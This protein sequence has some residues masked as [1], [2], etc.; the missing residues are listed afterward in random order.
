M[1][2]A[3]R[4]LRT[5]ESALPVMLHPKYT[6][7]LGFGLGVPKYSAGQWNVDRMYRAKNGLRMCVSGLL[8]SLKSHRAAIWEPPPPKPA[9]ER[10]ANASLRSP[11][12][13]G[14]LTPPCRAP[15]GNHRFPNGFSTFPRGATFSMGHFFFSA[16]HSSLFSFLAHLTFQ[17]GLQ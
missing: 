3:L 7:V 15:P 11:L 2:A 13:R 1:P 6:Q 14:G 5:K 10:G 17:C 12:L 4:M 8:G 9:P 16:I